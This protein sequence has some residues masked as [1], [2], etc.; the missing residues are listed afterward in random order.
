M[1]DCAAREVHDDSQQLKAS[2]FNDF[3][4]CHMSVQLF[5]LVLRSKNALKFTCNIAD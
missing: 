5:I 1:N 4:P 2:Q 3:F